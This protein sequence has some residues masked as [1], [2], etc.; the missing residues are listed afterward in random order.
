[1]ACY[2]KNVGLV[3]T[4]YK[5][6]LEAR[7]GIVDFYAGKYV[8]EPQQSGADS[9]TS[10]QINDVSLG[11]QMV[12][13][14]T[15]ITEIRLPA[16]Y[17]QI[18]ANAFVA[19]TNLTDVYIYA[20]E[21]IGI[22]S[23]AFFDASAVTV[24]VDYAFVSDYEADSPSWTVAGF[25]SGYTWEVPY[26][27]GVTPTTLTVSYL[28]SV[29][30]E[31]TEDAKAAVGKVIVPSYFIAYQN[32][33]VQTILD[34]FSNIITLS[35]AMEAGTLDWSINGEAETAVSQAIENKGSTLSEAF[36]TARAFAYSK[37]ITTLTASPFSEPGLYVCPPLNWPL[38]G[39]GM[40]GSVTMY[41]K[42]AV[43]SGAVRGMTEMIFIDVDIPNGT[44]NNEFLV[45]CSNLQYFHAR[46]QNGFRPNWGGVP[47]YGSLAD[48][49]EFVFLG[50]T[51]SPS[52]SGTMTFSTPS[53]Q[54]LILQNFNWS[55]NIVSATLLTR[56]ALVEF[57]TYLGTPS[58]TQTI[59][60]G[61]TN[62]AKLTAEDIAIATAKNWNVV[63]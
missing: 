39:V 24:H 38:A 30:G 16:D 19:L 15:E 32:N 53:L 59:K 1:M 37:G 63:A 55:L 18:G 47:H 2:K 36:A 20:G 21:K 45:Y 28:N 46:T 62:L 5:S 11:K 41:A 43:S 61:A 57:F 50:D 8:V 31:M 22:A 58:T 42:G 4:A 27:E 9:L 7:S 29:I 49:K 6:K 56:E 54:K 40:G 17:T 12:T 33:A 10:V 48:L 44:N 25:A 51:S 34:A 14:P 52:A 26:V 60:V 23:N 3:K 35:L 13:A